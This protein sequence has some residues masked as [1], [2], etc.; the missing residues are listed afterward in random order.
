MLRDACFRST[1]TPLIA[2]AES[3]VLGITVLRSQRRGAWLGALRKQKLGDFG[4]AQVKLFRL[5]TP[6]IIRTM[7]IRNGSKLSMGS[8]V[9]VRMSFHQ[10]RDEGAEESQALPLRRMLCTNSKKPR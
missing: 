7:R 8:G 6:Y 5:L 1:P 9:T 4:P 10:H 2:E 3:D